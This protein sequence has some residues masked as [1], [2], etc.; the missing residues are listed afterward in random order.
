[1][2]AKHSPTTATIPQ[3]ATPDRADRLLAELLKEKFS[4]SGVA[5]LIRLGRVRVSGRA[6]Q[7]STIL[8]PGD[9]VEIDLAEQKPI[10]DLAGP[11]PLV[12]ILFEDED[13]IVVNK[14]PGL[15]VHPGAG[16]PVSTLVDTLV[17]SRPEMVGVGQYGRWG[18]VHRL[19]KDTSGV[20][21]VAKSQKAYQALSAAFKEH[22]IHRVYLALVRGEP[23][24]DEGMVDKPLGR[25]AKDRKRISTATTKP[26]A[27]ITRWKV[28]ERLGGITLLGVT[29]KTGRT[30]QIRVHLASIGLPVAGD[31]VYGRMRKKTCLRDTA[32]RRGLESLKRQALH[33]AVLGFTHPRSGEYMEFSAPMPEDM[34][35]AVSMMRSG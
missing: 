2:S 11:A 25:H 18:V 15:V 1:M 29:P 21:V 28:L 19:D 4:R 33:A 3:N 26:R 32:L 22:S 10:L 17:S 35:T 9:V 6:I 14:P 20:M 12:D 30:H 7:P 34:A 24:A 16:R 27:A 23:S 13:L 5:R 31:P 8:K